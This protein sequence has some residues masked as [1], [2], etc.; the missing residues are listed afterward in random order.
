MPECKNSRTALVY[1]LPLALLIGSLFVGRYQISVLSVVDESMKA[2]SSLFFGTPASVSTQHTVLFNVRLP[3]IL[4]ALL[5]GTALSTAGASFQGIFRN[6]LVSPY[7]LGVGAGAGFGACLA[8]L[9]WDN[10]LLIQLMA[11]AFGLLVMFLAISMGKAS[12]GS[13]TLVFVLSGIIVSS[14]FTAL[15]SLV[16]YVADPYDELPTIVFWLMGSLANVRYGDLLYIIMPMFVGALVLFLLRWRINILALGDE[17]AKALGM[18]VEKMRLVIIV[19]ATLL[20]S[21]AVSISGVIGWV[22]L[23]VPHISRMI[24][25]PNYSR[26]LPMSAVIGA[27][28]MLLVDD[29]SRTIVATEIPLGILTSLVGAPLFAYLIRRGRMGWN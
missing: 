15:T 17:E 11:F 6:P 13:G 16:K 9:L 12:K 20:T 8:I 26:L 29:L 10:Y 18:N 3:R 1:M 21:A 4:A 27:S 7:I 22:G 28:F 5:V 14:I 23:V 25:G 24:V 19:C 2:F